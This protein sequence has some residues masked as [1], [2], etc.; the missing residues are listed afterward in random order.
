[1]YRLSQ[2]YISTPFSDLRTILRELLNGD[3]LLP[4]DTDLNKRPSLF[5]PA[6]PLVGWLQ[7]LGKKRYT[8]ARENVNSGYLASGVFPSCGDLL[9]CRVTIMEYSPFQCYCYGRLLPQGEGGSQLESTQLSLT[10]NLFFKMS[11]LPS[12]FA[13][14]AK[15]FASLSGLRR[16]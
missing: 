10:K 3:W 8:V 2:A 7:L 12:F 5:I 4:E 16:F 11:G 14:Y 6:C 13:S 1:M 15:P 9:M